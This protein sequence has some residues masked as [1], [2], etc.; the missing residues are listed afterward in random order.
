MPSKR[1]RR[2]IRGA[3]AVVSGGGA[4]VAAIIYQ[5]EVRRE[6]SDI[7]R[8]DDRQEQKFE[9]RATRD[10]AAYNAQVAERDF[11]RHA[12]ESARLS[13]MMFSEFIGEARSFRGNP[14]SGIIGEPEF[15][16]R[17]LGGGA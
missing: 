11:I 8:R 15:M 2:W 9:R 1:G 13:R 6:V 16:N 7:Y 14:L 17:Y 5:E 10:A 4:A 3:A 12:N